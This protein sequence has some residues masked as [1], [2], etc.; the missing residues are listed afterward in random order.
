MV[1][2]KLG[3]TH[4]E[5]NEIVLGTLPSSFKNPSSLR[6]ILSAGQCI[7]SDGSKSDN[8]TMKVETNNVVKINVP[9]HNIGD[10]NI[11]YV[12][13]SLCTAGWSNF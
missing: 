3:K 7:S 4:G 5:T 6:K 1:L 10:T 12:Q 11:V 2:L 13:V 9:V 8:V